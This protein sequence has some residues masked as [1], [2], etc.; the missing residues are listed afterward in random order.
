MTHS[1]KSPR[2]SV[3]IPTWDR[4]GSLRRAVASALT[5]TLPPAE[6]LVCDDGSTDDSEHV[7]AGL[8]ET[9]VR[10][11]P[12]AHAGRPAVPRNRGL[13]EAGGE[14]IAFLDS[15]DAWLP[16]KLEKQMA[17]SS[18]TGC[19]ASCTNAWAVARGTQRRPYFRQS[20]PAVLLLDH[21][22]E[23]NPVICSSVLMH[24]SLLDVVAG[25]PEDVELAAIE[26]Y[27]LWLRVAALTGFAYLAEP[28]VEYTDEPALSIRKPG[29]SEFV[30]RRRVLRN[31]LSWAQFV[32]GLEP[33]VRKA[34]AAMRWVPLQE[35]WRAVRQAASR[36]RASRP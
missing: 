21:L 26:D 11:V 30:Q 15:D 9:S 3:I 5:Q 16:E 10:W 36:V 12:G 34:H 7:I 8:G 20:L 4:A 2:V 19:Q 24:T 18:R 6:I 22:T 17:A 35:A 13:R 28:L 25:F 14:W 32:P 1:A 31:F 29:G 27:A 33:H 23:G